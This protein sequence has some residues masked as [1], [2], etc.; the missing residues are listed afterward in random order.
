MTLLHPLFPSLLPGRATGRAALAAQLA[1]ALGPRLGAL[2]GTFL[3]S[4]PLVVG[5]ALSQALR[6]ETAQVVACLRREVA[7][8]VDP[9]GWRWGG[10]PDVL[11]V[12]LAVVED[13]GPRGW[14]LRVV[15]FQAFPSVAATGF[16][17]AEAARRLH[18]QL[19]SLRPWGGDPD[20]EAW[21][22]RMRSLL[23]PDGP[24]ALV[25]LSPPTQFTDWDFAAA[26]HLFDLPTAEAA[27]LRVQG[28]DAWLETGAGRRPLA[29]LCN[30]V[31][32]PELHGHP[33]GPRL[34]AA[35]EALPIPCHGHP[36]WYDRV[37]KGWLPKLEGPP[38][39]RALAASRAQDLPRPL[40]HYVLK[41]T[42]SWGGRAVILHPTPADLNGLD[43][44]GAWILQ[45]RF[46]QVP[47]FQDPEGHPIYG[48]FRVMLALDPSL[49][50]WPTMVLARLNRVPLANARSMDGSPCTGL[51]VAF[52]PDGDAWAAL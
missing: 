18:P 1:P 31:V 34:R 39:Q 43:D 44:P 26:A 4:V 52:L 5:E 13:P 28:G 36:A 47:L 12:D 22:R 8:G 32:P 2:G 3:A 38:A 7:Q 41:D 20:P 33:A 24:A 42:R 10:A 11:T 16:L 14:A 50:A 30:R 9:A 21:C 27:D 45:P 46:T 40:E 17:V 19:A 23:A 49:G 35:F 51:A 25:D 6:E 48:E 37:H 29:R 15:E